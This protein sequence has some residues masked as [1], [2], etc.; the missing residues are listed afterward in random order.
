MRHKSLVG[1]PLFFVAFAATLTLPIPAQIVST[2]APGSINSATASTPWILG[3]ARFD[4]EA[5]AGAES[6]AVYGA[7]IPLL[8]MEQ[9]PFLPD[10]PPRQPRTPTTSAST[11][12][13]AALYSAGRALATALDDKARIELDP[14][15]DSARRASEIRSVQMRISSA[16]TRLRELQ[17]AKNPI[18]RLLGNLGLSARVDP[19]IERVAT[20]VPV[21]AP[22]GVASPSTTSTTISAPSGSAQASGTQWWKGASS[23]ALPV[24]DPEGPAKTVAIERLDGLVF[25]SVHRKDK[26]L[27]VIVKAYERSTGTITLLY[28]GKTSV[29]TPQELCPAIA[30]AIEEWIA[31]RPLARLDLRVKPSDAKLTVDGVEY[32]GSSHRLFYYSPA[33]VA[34]VAEA[35]GFKTY[36]GSLEIV[37]GVDRT[38]AIE[39]PAIASRVVEPTARAALD[40]DLMKILDE[41]TTATYAPSFSAKKDKFYS[42]LGFFVGA[43]P[44]AIL[45]GGNFSIYAEAVA[46]TDD[47]RMTTGYTVSAAILGAGIAATA[48]FAVNAIIRLVDFLGAAH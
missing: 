35:E 41:G 31:D 7:M 25:G 21:S 38:I 15:M 16:Q 43:L 4:D 10:R 19:A 26:D 23:G 34:L 27:S 22:D 13:S 12:G 14:D 5:G 18:A 2:Q 17:S 37:P 40:P 20:V 3:I 9:L 48:F 36:R 44:C 45:A 11:T 8:V 6:A 29:R 24:L 47:S 30:A 1:I 39:L 42:A 28:T 32:L 33:A 46:R